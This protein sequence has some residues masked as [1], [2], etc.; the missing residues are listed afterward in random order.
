MRVTPLNLDTNAQPIATHSG[1][2]GRPAEPSAVPVMP[3]VAPT[4]TQQHAAA[5]RS[6]LFEIGTE[7]PS[8]LSFY[9]FDN[10]G[11]R[12]FGILEH[13]KLRR[14]VTE[15]NLRHQ[16]DAL[17]ACQDHSAYDLTVGD[18]QFLM[19]WHRINDFKRTPYTVEWL[20]N[21]PD[22]VEHTTEDYAKR[23]QRHQE[24]ADLSEI[25][26]KPWAAP[27]EADTLTNVHVLQRTN[28]DVVMLD[29]AACEQ[30]MADFEANYGFKLFPPMM[31]DVVSALEEEGIG[32]DLAAY[33]RYAGLLNPHVHGASLAERRHA[34]VDYSIRNPGLDI[35][36]DF[37]R[38]VS[39][40]DH[41][42][43]EAVEVVCKECGSKRSL[44]LR[45]D[46]FTFFPS[47]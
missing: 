19:Y 37:E 31:R 13:I 22:H 6:D 35:V 36:A 29:S 42:V 27:L 44:K 21:E 18:F 1:S 3:S 39:L 20:C 16:V 38:W 12:H 30:F 32:Q 8:R 10:L 9:G 24:T 47:I 33:N 28:M 34:L 41:G 15:E 46:P 11:V 4:E 23:F 26:A 14:S 40:S 43:K 45:V 25:E 5:T 7:L 2:F 17:S